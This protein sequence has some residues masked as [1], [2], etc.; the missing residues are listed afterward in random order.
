[1]SSNMEKIEIDLAPLTE[2][3]KKLFGIFISHSNSENDK[4]V[5]GELL[6]AMDTFL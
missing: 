1:M 4:A 2:G 6:E 3:E 5:C